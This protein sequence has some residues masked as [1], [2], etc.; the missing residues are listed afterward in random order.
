MFG[1]DF[2]K[3]EQTSVNETSNREIMWKWNQ[4][5]YLFAVFGPTA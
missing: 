3:L 1:H 2:P 4:A 5:S